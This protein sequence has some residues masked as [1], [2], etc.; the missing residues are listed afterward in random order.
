M[1]DLTNAPI[2]AILFYLFGA[3][4]NYWLL[5][6]YYHWYWHVESEYDSVT[7]LTHNR[8]SND[9]DE[10]DPRRRP[11]RNPPSNARFP[12][13]PT[14]TLQVMPNGASVTKMNGIQTRIQKHLNGSSGYPLM[15]N[16]IINEYSETPEAPVYPQVN[17]NIMNGYTDASGYPPMRK[18]IL[19]GSS[20]SFG[21]PQMGKT[22]LN[23]YSENSVT[24]GYSS[25]GKIML[26]GSARSSGFPQ[27]G[28]SVLNETSRSTG[29]SQLRK[30]ASNEPSGFPQVGKMKCSSSIQNN[31][32]YESVFE[33]KNPDDLYFQF[34]VASAP[35]TTRKSST[36]SQDRSPFAS[37]AQARYAKFNPTSDVP[38]K[39]SLNP[40]QGNKTG[41]RP[42]SHPRACSTSPTSRRENLIISQIQSTAI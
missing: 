13:G 38:R 33:Y 36:V 39:S 35:V 24:S 16:S 18:T 40:Y 22:N 23:E 1:G 17:N 9:I 21:C 15:E 2:F 32:I 26:N 3:L 10:A 8:L 14:T 20:S 6:V 11:F 19:N 27:V 29:S 5:Y 41:T 31:N 12:T 25:V 37:L 28:S 30:T 7:K 4:M 34:P 42:P